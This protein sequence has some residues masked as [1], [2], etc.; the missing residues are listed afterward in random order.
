M[1]FSTKSEKHTQSKFLK[2]GYLIFD[3]DQKK[4]LYAIKKKVLE[5]SRF[6]L[7]KKSI[8]IKNKKNL[9]DIIHI[10]LDK[11]ELNEFRLHIYNQINNSKNFQRIYYNLAKKYLDMLCGNE[12]VMQKN[13]TSVYRCQMMI[14]HY[15]PYMQM[16]GL[17][18]LSMK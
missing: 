1:K 7:K 10:Y 3:I 12:L 6:W 16:Y 15:C 17:E 14:A 5:L 18:T 11:K 13:V 9:L 8:K 2:N 4:E